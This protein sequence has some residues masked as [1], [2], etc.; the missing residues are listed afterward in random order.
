MHGPRD[1]MS[2]ACDT[3]NVN[4]KIDVSSLLSI[5][6]NINRLW[7]CVLQKYDRTQYFSFK[8][9]RLYHAKYPYQRAI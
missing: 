6:I 3:E 2:Q 5:F 8:L 9:Y 1:S 7:K 4:R